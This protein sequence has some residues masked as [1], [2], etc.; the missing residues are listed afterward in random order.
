MDD[1]QQDVEAHGLA[2][3]DAMDRADGHVRDERER[4]LVEVLTTPLF[5]NPSA[6]L[7]GGDVNP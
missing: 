2:V 4:A 7:F 3:L 5:A 1:A 6:E